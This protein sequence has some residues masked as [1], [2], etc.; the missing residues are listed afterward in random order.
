MLIEELRIPSEVDQDFA[1][2]VD[3]RNAIETDILGTDGL[4]V[5]A[6][7]LL[8]FYQVQEYEPKRMFVVRVD[9]RIVGRG[10]L[11]WAGA[12]SWIVGEILRGYRGRGLGTALFDHLEGLAVESGRAVVQ[13]AA[14]HTVPTGGERIASPTGFG[15]LAAVDPGV[16]FLRARGYEL[17]QIKRISFLEL[18]V[19]P[20]TLADLRR[21][22]EEKAGPDYQLVEWSGRTP[23]ARLKD[24]A[25]L[26]SRMSTDA[27][28]SGLDPDDGLWDAG[29]VI[30]TD[31]KLLA[32]GTLPLVT[33]VEHRPTGTLV[34][35]TEL[36]LRP[37][38]TRPVTQHDTLVHADHRGHRLG[39]LLK[40]ANLQ[41]LARV[42]PAAT[43][44][45][46]FN[47]EENRHMLAINET[48]G[49]RPAGAE[50][51]WRRTL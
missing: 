51:A 43:L 8:P 48:I 6:A 10:I 35:F 50:G 40:I 20:A 30:A 38:R 46:A 25:T 12:V 17:Q 36:W 1:E 23:P 44:V 42:N 31:N 16:R 22:A 3:V 14:I 39:M 9:G 21:Q 5:E 26:K 37:D 18:P 49:F 19:D 4:S 47:A 13:S 2:M 24:L 33:A 45:N 34:G 32:G 41:R 29:R 27:P 15:D 7:A 11:S 28:A